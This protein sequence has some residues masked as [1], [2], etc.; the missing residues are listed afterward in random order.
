MA[1]KLA[2]TTKWKYKNKEDPLLYVPGGGSIQCLETFWDIIGRD[3]SVSKFNRL[4]VDIFRFI[5]IKT[6]GTFYESL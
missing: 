2:D 3:L 5:F 4:Q 6:K 1:A